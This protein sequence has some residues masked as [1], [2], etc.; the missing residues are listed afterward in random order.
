[1]AVWGGNSNAYTA[2]ITRICETISVEWTNPSV[3]A[4][5]T[6]IAYEDVSKNG[7]PC[8]SVTRSANCDTLRRNP[9]FISK[10]MREIISEEKSETQIFYWKTSECISL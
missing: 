1:M 5:T 4:Y 9:H 2:R 6:L 10:R 7:I 8:T 3:W